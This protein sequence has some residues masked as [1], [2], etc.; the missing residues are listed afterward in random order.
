MHHYRQFFFHGTSHWLGLD[1]HDR[2]RYRL[3]GESR[4]LSA[5]MVFTVEPGL[6]VDASRPTRSYAMLEYDLDSWT[7]ERILKGDA[8]RRRQDETLENADQ[9]TWDVPEE[10]LGLGIRIEDDIL[11]VDGGHENLTGHVPSRPDKVEELCAERS[12]LVRE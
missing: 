6:Y 8:A 9:V 7:E 10:F 4:E 5:G 2:G 1:V 11:I 12:W 3:D